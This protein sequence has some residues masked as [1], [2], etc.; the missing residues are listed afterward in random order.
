MGQI[1]VSRLDITCR[2]LQYLNNNFDAFDFSG[3]YM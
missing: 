2:Y 3:W 1:N